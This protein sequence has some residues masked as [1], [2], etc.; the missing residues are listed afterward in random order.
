[1][2]R[3]SIIPGT[4]FSVRTTRIFQRPGTIFSVRTTRIF[5]KTFFADVTF[6]RDIDSFTYDNDDFLVLVAAGNRGHSGGVSGTPYTVGSPATAKNNMAV[7]AA[8]NSPTNSMNLAYFSSHGPT[9]YDQR[10]ASF[11]IH[12]TDW[13]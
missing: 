11:M 9:K 2:S 13:Q 6:G 5:Q 7:G 10:F 3:C 8:S 12:T 4:I 1:M